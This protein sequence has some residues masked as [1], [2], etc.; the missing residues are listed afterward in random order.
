MVH[1]SIDSDTNSIKFDVDL[2]SLPDIESDG[3]E[4]IVNFQVENF[5]NNQTF[6]TDSNGLEMQKRIINYRPTWDIQKN[7][8]DSNENITANYYPINSAIAMEDI[9]QNKRFV[10]CNDR[11]QSGSALVPGGVQFMQNRRIPADDNRGMGEYVDET[12]PSTGRGINVYATYYV[13]IFNAKARHSAQ[14]LI[15]Q[16]TD[17]PPR[18]LYADKIQQVGKGQ[19]STLSED[20]IKYGIKDTVKMVSLP[21]GRYKFLL[22]L[23]NIADLMDFTEMPESQV[24]D[25]DLVKALFINVNPGVKPEEVSYTFTEK[26]LS[27]NMDIEEMLKRKIDWKTIDDLK[28]DKEPSKKLSYDIF[29]DS[30]LELVPQR[31]RVFEI[32]FGATSNSDA[33]FLQS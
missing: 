15:Q 14:R 4:V 31:I 10:V 2:G 16:R 18:Y 3:H 32:S 28:K 8:H 13:Q 30:K 22:R 23:E 25:L 29:E 1:V 24:V 17:D 27:A 7:Y 6:Y 11:P 21:L 12:D 19:A 26:S 33:L 20:L 5:D 9:A